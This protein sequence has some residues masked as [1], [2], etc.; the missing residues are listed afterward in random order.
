MKTKKMICKNK[1]RYGILDRKEVVYVTTDGKY[2]IEFI[3][4]KD[5]WFNYLNKYN[6][7][8]SMTNNRPTVKTSIKGTTKSVH[9]VICEIIYNE[10]DMWGRSV[11]HINV[12]KLDNRISNLRLVSHRINSMIQQN[13]EDIKIYETKNICGKTQYMSHF[14]INGKR[15]YKNSINKETIEQ[16]IND[17]IHD[18]FNYREQVIMEAEKKERIFELK[19][20]IKG[21]LE[22]NE[23][24]ELNDILIELLGIS[25]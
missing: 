3:V 15:F 4:D 21:M 2:S 22:N 14:M 24:D 5:M 8:V 18:I 13:Y 25:I 7:T 10:E 6:W 9:T 20:S 17:N 12:N 1:V 19:R 23:Q 11:D 16:F